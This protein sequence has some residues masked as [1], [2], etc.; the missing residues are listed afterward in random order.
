VNAKAT[1]LYHSV[2]HPG[3]TTRIYG[4]VAICYD[5]DFA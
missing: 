1:A 2:C 4:D 3:T 5:E